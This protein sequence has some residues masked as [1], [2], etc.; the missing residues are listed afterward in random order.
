MFCTTCQKQTPRMLDMRSR[1]MRIIQVEGALCVCARDV[2][3]PIKLNQTLSFL[4]EVSSL[5]MLMRVSYCEESRETLAACMCVKCGSIRD[6]ET[7][8]EFSFLNTSE[9]LNHARR[10]ENTK[11]PESS[12]S[13]SS[14]S[15]FCIRLG[16]EPVF[17][18]SSCVICIKCNRCR[19]TLLLTNA[20]VLSQLSSI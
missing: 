4:F 18:S 1:R 6:D 9:R 8:G 16:H 10:S 20:I 3:Q 7:R 15:F 12:S 2:Q 5:S 11:T 17:L 13:S 14:S 19:F